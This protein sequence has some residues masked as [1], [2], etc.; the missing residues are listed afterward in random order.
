[1]T[2]NASK[3]YTQVVM[4]S[5]VIVYYMTFV[6]GGVSSVLMDR[7]LRQDTCGKST[8]MWKYA[9]LN[10]I[11]AALTLITYISFPGGGE[12]ARA[13]ALMI[14]ILHLG[15]GTWGFLLRTSLPDCLAVIHDHY[16]H[17][18]FFFV[19]CLWHNLVFFVLYVSHELYL[20][21]RLGGDLTLIPEV[22]KHDSGVD[23]S[24]QA[25]EQHAAQKAA[26]LYNSSN[27]SPSPHTLKSSTSSVSD[28]PPLLKGGGGGG[29]GGDG[30]PK[31]M[32]DY[33][34]LQTT[35]I[36]HTST[37]FTSN[38]PRLPPQRGL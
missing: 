1:M 30:S 4:I 7:S 28:V 3:A 21:E 13:R 8:H 11:F 12:G 9:V 32:K 15:L 20:G 33:A 24:Y 23:F 26:A 38:D 27:D 25:Q 16:S 5:A 22:R 36:T 18:H 14:S 19:V 31:I 2:L 6:T 17:I 35:D 37:A 34:V 29:G 10:T